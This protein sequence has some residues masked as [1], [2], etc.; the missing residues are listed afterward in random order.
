[1]GP[2]ANLVPMRMARGS[3][4][5]GAWAGHELVG[6]GWLSVTSE[7]IGEVE[8]EVILAAREAYVWNCVTLDRHR[9]KG[10][11]R[12]LVCSLVANAREE[13]FS[14]L[15]IGSVLDLAG[16]AIRQAGF[17]PVLRFETCLRFGF[18]WLRVV[19][20]KGADPTLV[21]AAREV[22]AVKPGPS[23][24]RSKPRLH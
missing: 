17:V 19:P 4:C 2:E 23:L 14:R 3:R 10:V 16:N 18:R 15:W 7:W 9:R 22:L 12:S 5:F 1:M 20:V 24:R 6:Y 8:L 11:F 21:A 13:G